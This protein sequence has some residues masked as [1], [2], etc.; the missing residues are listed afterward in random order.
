MKKL[1]PYIEKTRES[2]ILT[3]ARNVMLAYVLYMICRIAFVCENWSLY[4]ET[5]FENSFWELLCGSLRF[6]TSAI[7]YTNALYALMMLFPRHR[8]EQGT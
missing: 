4:K 6:D 8:Q 7:A 5:L 3:F 1:W 2:S